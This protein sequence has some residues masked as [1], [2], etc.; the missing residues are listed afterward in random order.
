MAGDKVTDTEIING[1][2]W[3][4]KDYTLNNDDDYVNFVFSRGTVADAYQSQTV[5]REYINK[6]SFFTISS[7][8]KETN[9]IYKGLLQNQH[10]RESVWFMRTL[11]RYQL[12]TL[13]ELRG[14]RERYFSNVD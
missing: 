13:I 4:Y 1:K 12:I 11:G 14:V 3:F 7:V 5:D 9:S 8:R 6:T 2:K 10:L